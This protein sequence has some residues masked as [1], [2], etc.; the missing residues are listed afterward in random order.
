MVLS[1]FE[2]FSVSFIPRWA[3]DVQL[4]APQALCTRRP[5]EEDQKTVTAQRLDVVTQHRCW[6]PLPSRARPVKHLNT[7]AWK[8]YLHRQNES[9]RLRFDTSA[10]LLAHGVER[11]SPSF[12]HAM[13]S[14]CF[15]RFIF[16]WSSGQLTVACLKPK[17]SAHVTIRLLH[18][19]PLS[20]KRAK[21][22]PYTTV[23]S[24]HLKP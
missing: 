21:L 1:C 11:K 24:E 4:I 18:E 16:D 14:G 9:K 10:H 22:L 19:A 3:P 8:R 17:R 23:P 2:P 7:K 20:P 6:H 13:L 5:C 12:H 15:L